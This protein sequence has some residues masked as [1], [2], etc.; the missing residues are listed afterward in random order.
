M[1]HIIENATIHAERFFREDVEVQILDSGWVY[2]EEMDEY[3]PPSKI[4]KIE[5]Q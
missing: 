3:Y 1:T 4:K 2:I 5:P